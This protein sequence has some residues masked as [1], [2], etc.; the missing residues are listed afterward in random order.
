[1][2]RVD[3][4]QS[5]CDKCPET[6]RRLEI[7]S[8]SSKVKRGSSAAATLVSHSLHHHSR[9]LKIKK[10]ERGPREVKDPRYS[11]TPLRGSSVGPTIEAND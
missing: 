3:G 1:M 5:P 4:E 11:K 8:G 2:R 9:K 7:H 6:P 10:L